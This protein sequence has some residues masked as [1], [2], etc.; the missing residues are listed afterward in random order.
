MK[1]NHAI[2]LRQ[3]DGG[4]LDGALEERAAEAEAL[5]TRTDDDG[6][7]LLLVA[8]HNDLVGREVGERHRRL[9]LGGHLSVVDYQLQ[10][11]RMYIRR[12]FALNVVYE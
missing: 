3:P 11:T 12:Y 7:A 9:G 6:S 8:Q 10:Q 1:T 2:V 5:R 4:F